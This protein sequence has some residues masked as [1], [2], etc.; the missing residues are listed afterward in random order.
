MSKELEFRLIKPGSSDEDAAFEIQEQHRR[1]FFIPERVFRKAVSKELVLGAFQDGKVVAYLWSSKKDG[2][3]RVRYLSVHQNKARNGIGRRLVD[4]LKRRHFDAFRIQLSC[5]TDYPGWR[6]WKGVGFHALRNRPGRAKAGSEVT[7]FIYEL[8]PLPLFAD[9]HSD[10][11]RPKVAIDAN[12]YFDLCDKNRPHHLES[13][14]LLAEWV[15]A[16]FDL[17]VTDALGEDIARGG[18]LVSEYEWPVVKASKEAFECIHQ[19]VVSLI[20]PGT[21]EQDISDRNH[22][23]H[24]LAENVHTFVTRDGFLLENA[25]KIYDQFG[26][27]VLRP[28]DFV[29]NVDT[30]SN[31]FTF[32]RRDLESVRL[33]ISKV[34]LNDAMASGLTNL[35]R[36]NEKASSLQ[37]KLRGWLAHPGR[38]EVLSILDADDTTQAMCA[39]EKTAGKVDVHLFR[40]S[41]QLKG[42]RKGRTILRCLAAQLRS[43]SPDPTFIKITDKVGVSEAN[44]ALAELGFSFNGRTAYKVCLP[45]VWDLHD[46]IDAARVLT[47]ENSEAMSWLGEQALST[48]STEP[49]LYLGLEH[50]LWPAK[51][52]SEGCVPCIAIP[53][54]PPWARALFD[55]NLGQAELWDEDANLLL[56]PTNAYYTGARP[57]IEYGRILWYVSSDENYPGSKHARA[58]SQLTRRVIAP[59]VQSY[60]EFRHFGVY[61]LTDIERLAKP[62][63]PDVLAMEFRDTELLSKP[64]SLSTIRDVLGNSKEA[65][66]WPTKIEESDFLEIYQKGIG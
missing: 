20:G 11:E 15:D 7:D 41:V 18:H 23:S 48:F 63:R 13:S 52:R 26:T 55:P 57:G 17:C 51:I 1:Y 14:G 42:R 53:I 58:T 34:D 6:F 56:N 66:Q 40:T 31:Q 39:I 27:S 46:A 16:E 45:G 5:R 65:F 62:K 36:Q 32:N 25:D 29:L 38:F 2:T 59:P 30:A 61:Q 8:T 49:L 9:Q 37:A 28:V 35:I 44:E 33:S 60:R 50:H 64:I 24:A 12:V 3:V 4:E 10:D 21:N 54:R 47:S 22:L 19:Q 43:R